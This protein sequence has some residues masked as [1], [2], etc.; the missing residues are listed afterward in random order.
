[1]S[2]TVKC[3]DRFTYLFPMSAMD[4]RTGELVVAEAAAFFMTTTMVALF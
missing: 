3:V 2:A 4:L 1:M